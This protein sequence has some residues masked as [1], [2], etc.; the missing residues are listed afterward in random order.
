MLTL[1]TILKTTKHLS[2]YKSDGRH[3]FGDE[4]RTPQGA[5]TQ[6]S[7]AEQDS[8]DQSKD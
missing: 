7:S 5:P 4:P 8:S 2:S 6:A 3:K 1:E